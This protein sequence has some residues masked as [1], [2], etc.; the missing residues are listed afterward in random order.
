[1]ATDGDPTIRQDGGVYTALDLT[2]T[3]NNGTWTFG[4]AAQD[5]FTQIQAL[6]TLQVPAGTYA[7][8]LTVPME[9]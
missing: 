7:D 6:R 4:Q 8:K 2:N 5:V 3:L 1:M 9:Y